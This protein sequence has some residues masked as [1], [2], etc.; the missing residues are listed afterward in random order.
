MS[1]KTILVHVDQS[2]HAAERIRL[3]AAIARAENAHLIGAAMTGISRYV[4]DSGAIN[5]HDAVLKHHLDFLHDYARKALQVFE[6][7]AAAAGVNSV[8]SRLVDDDAGG[9]MT[10]QAR[11]C[12]LVVLG[13][14][15]PDEAVPGLMPDFPEYVVMNCARPVLVV[16]FASQLMGK[17]SEPCKRP[18][19][20]WDASMTATRAVTSALPLLAQADQADLVVF[21]ADDQPDAHGEQP[22]A[23]L[24]LYLARHGVKLNVI[25]QTIELDTG[26][27]LLSLAAD[28]GSDMI[29]MGG[30]GH[31]RFREIILGGATRTM[32]A[33]MTVPVLMAH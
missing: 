22:G 27:A 7:L 12:D 32:L 14:I 3:A 15:N 21:N 23:D 11:Y 17:F 10:L 24:A 25:N 31:T 30:Y 18:L 6:Q 28:R 13:Q 2:Q 9:G 29:V 4:F 16:P 5:P 20:A 19:I 26:N 8:E 33:S 1:Y